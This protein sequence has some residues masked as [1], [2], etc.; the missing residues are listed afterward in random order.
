MR[1]QAAIVGDL[2]A[3]MAKEIAGAEQAV[4]TAMAEAAGGLKE[5]LRGQVKTAS[6]GERLAKTW[7]DQVYPKGQKSISAAALVWSKAPELMDAFNRG[8]TIRSR[9]GFFLAIPTPAAGAQRGS[10]FT[11]RLTPGGWERRTGMRLR[12]V[13]RRGAP[14][15]LVADNARLNKKG[16]AVAN[17]GR[18]KGAMF[19]RLANRV[20]SVI[21]ILVP[22]VQLRRRLDVEAAG[23][24]WQSRLP[25][26]ILKAWPEA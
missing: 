15:L 17:T 23:T 19:T 22:Q 6:L 11:S 10:G 1:L 24:L 16:H 9:D 18:R 25:A 26:L 8:V 7:R 2:K 21:F 14:S 13:Y 4:T 3:Y 5:T 20:T 12:F